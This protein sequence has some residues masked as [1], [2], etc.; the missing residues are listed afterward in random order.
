M[1]GMWTH[2]SHRCLPVLAVT[3]SSCPPRNRDGDMAWSQRLGHAELVLHLAGR[4]LRVTAPYRELLER[5]TSVVVPPCTVEAS[6]SGP[7]WTLSIEEDVCPVDDEESGLERPEL[8]YS[9]HGPRLTVLDSHDGRTRVAGR[10]RPSSAAASIEVDTSACATRLLLPAGDVG[11]ARWG[12]WLMKTFY[13]SRL[14]AAGWQMLHASAVA[15]D[16]EAMLF[17]ATSR[18]G[19]STLAHRACTELGAAF[20]A[21]DLVLLGPDGTVVGWPTRVSLP[22]DLP[23]LAGLGVACDRVADGRVRRR[24]MLTPP[25]HRTTL[26]ITYS[27]PV[28]LGTVVSLVSGTPDAAGTDARGAGRRA[29][30]VCHLDRDAVARARVEALDV[31][32]QR[33]FTSDLLGLTGGPRA[34]SPSATGVDVA[35]LLSRAPGALLRIMDP[36]ALSTAPVWDEL[37]QF[38]PGLAAHLEVGRR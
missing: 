15:L 19:K 37:A 5:V 32:R 2:G 17:L 9:H 31:P 3:Y 6:S 1:G 18:G 13:A 26:G 38:V 22:A 36:E 24:R 20:L 12:D 16:G 7:E 34:T 14:L 4:R 30:Q 33:L 28:P 29:L 11:A 35:G 8:V 21:D 27:P 25:E 10:Y 23:G